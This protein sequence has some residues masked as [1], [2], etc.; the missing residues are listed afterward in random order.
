MRT[1]PA[2]HLHTTRTPA[3]GYRHGKQWAHQPLSAHSRIAHTP[4]RVPF[5]PSFHPSRHVVPYLDT[6]PVLG[7]AP[8]HDPTRGRAVAL[9]LSILG[10]SMVGHVRALDAHGGRIKAR[11]TTRLQLGHDGAPGA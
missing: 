9:L 7:I 4:A 6:A 8:S 3:R 10:C 5:R 11:T 1:R 2:N